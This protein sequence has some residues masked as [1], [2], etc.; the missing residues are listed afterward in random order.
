M[1]NLS[2]AVRA[3]LRGQQTLAPSESTGKPLCS[4]RHM[5]LSKFRRALRAVAT[6]GASSRL[7]KAHQKP[8]EKEE[9]KEQETKT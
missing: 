8:E 9:E 1:R 7:F 5:M 4:A 6:G 2:R 3:R